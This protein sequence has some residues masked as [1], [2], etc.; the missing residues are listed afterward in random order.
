M[1]VA[2]TLLGAILVADAMGGAAVVMVG[3]AVTRA[4]G[5]AVVGMD[6]VGTAEDMGVVG[7]GAVGMAVVRIGTAALPTGGG[8]IHTR[9]VT[10]LMVGNS[11]S[12]QEPP[13]VAL[14]RRSPAVPGS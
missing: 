3:V 12:G 14:S 7:T 2:V 13:V 8:V 9:M 10:G 1:G 11:A 4:A 5:T 6:G